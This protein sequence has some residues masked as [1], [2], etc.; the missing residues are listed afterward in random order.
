MMNKKLNDYKLNGKEGKAESSMETERI[1]KAFSQ[2]GKKE[3][4]IAKYILSQN[5]MQYETEYDCDLIHWTDEQLMDLF[6]RKMRFYKMFSLGNVMSRYHAF[7][8]YCEQQGLI[9]KNPFQKSMYLSYDYLTRMA[10]E[11]G[12]V[13]FYSREYVIQTCMEADNPA[14][15]LS[16]AL[17]VYEGIKCYKDLALIKYADVDFK[18]RRIAGYSFEFSERLMEAYKSM[19]TM[20]WYQTYRNRQYFDDSEGYLIRRIIA[21]GKSFAKSHSVRNIIS[22]KMQRVGL[23]QTVLYDSGLMKRLCTVLGTE[24]LLACFFNEE[25]EEKAAN[26]HKLEEAFGKLGIEMSVKNFLYDYRVY[27]LGYKYGIFS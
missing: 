5:P 9:E 12:N 6:I 15:I 13:P 10:V 3:T 2:Q 24:Q 4:E 22:N 20:E 21:N 23:E 11:A 26:R 1:I 27:A 7:Y 8:R 17:S 14:Y 25:K 16:V 18:N 19:H